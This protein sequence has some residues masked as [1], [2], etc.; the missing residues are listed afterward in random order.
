MATIK[1]TNSELNLT[2]TNSKVKLITQSEGFDFEI[3]RF[4]ISGRVKV[5]SSTK[6]GTLTINAYP[7][8]NPTY[9]TEGKL[10]ASSDTE[11]RYTKVPQLL[12]N[13]LNR[14]SLNNVTLVRKGTEKD[15]K[16]NS[17]GYT[18]D[19]MYEAK[20][21]LF[22]GDL[23]FSIL[24]RVSS[25]LTERT[26]FTGLQNVEAGDQYVPLTGEVRKITLTGSPKSTAKII[27][28]KLS[29]IK[30]SAGNII[31]SSETSILSKTVTQTEQSGLDRTGVPINVGTVTMDENGKASFYQN[32]KQ[33][34]TET[35]YKI[36]V[37][38]SELMTSFNTSNWVRPTDGSFT[39]YWERSLLM[40][41]RP[42]VSFRTITTWSNATVDKD[43]SG[44]FVT[45]S[46][47]APINED[48]VGKYNTF[49]NKIT[50][51]SIKKT[52]RFKY[53]F[54]ATSGSFTLG[55][56]SDGAGGTRG[57]PLYSRIRGLESDWTNSF[58]NDDPE[59]GLT[60]NGGTIVD[61]EGI[62]STISTTSSSNDTLTLIFTARIIKWGT[63]QITMELDTDKIA[64][65]A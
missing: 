8:D 54:K 26:G 40:T 30:D 6:I 17:V 21:G 23:S 42:S 39:D 46:A 14:G 35:R 16:N 53:I 34:T 13:R 43:G 47:V 51:K 61:I 15:T 49:S 22:N 52:I 55:T 20:D 18:F 48:Y 41:K 7:G 25:K 63:E 36:R 32:F 57:N 3:Q 28:T 9:N 19:I 4:N 12:A 62:S 24:E 2:S 31:D 50:S 11:K 44:T 56:G 33:E 59:N 58:P 1:Q 38:A 29:D 45:F 64:A 37:L 27:I 10:N 65:L 60:G 5:G